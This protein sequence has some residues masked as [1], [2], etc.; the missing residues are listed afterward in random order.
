MERNHW[1]ALLASSAAVLFC[2]GTASAQ[3]SD[4]IDTDSLIQRVAFLEEQVSYAEPCG[5]SCTGCGDTCC[6]DSCCRSSCAAGRVIFQADLLFF[7]FFE[8]DGVDENPDNGTDRFDFEASPRITLGYKNA[9]GLSTRLRYFGYNH[10]NNI[11]NQGNFEIDTYNIDFELAQELKVG[12][13]TRMEFNMGCRFNS[14]EHTEYGNTEIDQ[15]FEGIGLTFGTELKRDLG[16]GALY[17]RGRYAILVGEGRDHEDGSYFG[18][19]VLGQLELGVGYE[20]VRCMSSGCVLSLRAGIE[21]Q[22][23]LGYEDEEEDV[24]FGGFLCSA[25]VSY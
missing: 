20:V 16:P 1:F 24:G 23:W 18:D 7:R 8:A 5:R 10:S 12:R 4:Y 9:K 17:G 19:Q 22:Q 21:M 6:S 15:E 11:D 13:L 2:S 25:G 3:N 14:Y